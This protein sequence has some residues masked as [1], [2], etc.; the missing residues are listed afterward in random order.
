MPAL[1]HALRTERSVDIQSSSLIAL[2][3]I[4][5]EPKSASPADGSALV[6]VI[7]PFLANANQEVAESAALALGILGDERSVFVLADLVADNASGRRARGS[8]QVDLRT[9]SFAAFGLGLVGSRTQREDVRRFCVS[10]LVSALDSDDTAS[11][12][13]S[14]ACAMSI[15]LIPLAIAAEETDDVERPASTSR[16]AQVAYLLK[17]FEDRRKH[18]FL[19]RAHLAVAAARL[20]AGLGNVWKTRVADALIDSISA[21][22][23][24]ERELQQACALALGL[25]GDDD[26]DDVD[27]RIRARLVKLIDEADVLARYHALVSLAYIAARPGDGADPGSA[28]ELAHPVSGL[29]PE[30]E[31]SDAIDADGRRAAHLDFE[32]PRAV[33]EKAALS[34]ACDHF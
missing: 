31:V 27:E 12:D 26:A 24:P 11:R 6:E 17:A 7:R 33:T 15:G 21:S 19:V 32:R 25:L 28:V 30:I 1:I 14:V 9:R 22:A 34:G 20:N 18:R 2:A 5:I 10:R 3:K 16:Q 29:L 23:K 8:K 4:G 13:L